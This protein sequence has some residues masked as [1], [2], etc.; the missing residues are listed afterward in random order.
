MQMAESATL[1]AGQ[2]WLIEE[3]E[4]VDHVAETEAVDE[5]A[6]GPAEDQME[7]RLQEAIADRAAERVGHDDEEHRDGAEVEQHGDDLR[8]RICADAE[9]RAGIAHVHDL[10]DV[11]DDGH[12]IVQVDVRGHQPF[13]PGVEDDDC[14]GNEEIGETFHATAFRFSSM[15]LSSSA[16]RRP[17]ISS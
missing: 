2:W 5:V 14:R 7:P 9:R 3:I 1:N 10:E 15:T 13:R 16:R 8:L 4:E 6:D 12:G 17:R 11:G